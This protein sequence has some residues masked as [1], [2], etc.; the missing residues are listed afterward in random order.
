MTKQRTA[1]RSEAKSPIAAGATPERGGL[2]SVVL[3]G[4]LSRPAAE[5]LLP[6]GGRLVVLDLTVPRAG[7]RAEGIPVVWFDPPTWADELDAGR[8]VLVV[9]R[10]RRRF[11]R[12]GAATASRTEVVAESVVRVGDTRRELSA[13]TRV[14][15]ALE[16]ATWPTVG[17]Q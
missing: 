11:Y 17:G 3:I 14:L 4:R 15:R 6:S 12:T 8:G 13:L 16:E 9:G 5:R 7:E 1:G 2:N 10:V